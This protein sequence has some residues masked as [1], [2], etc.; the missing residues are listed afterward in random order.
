VTERLATWTRKEGDDEGIPSF[1]PELA[2]TAEFNETCPAYKERYGKRFEEVLHQ[3][4]SDKKAFIE[5]MEDNWD[6]IYKSDCTFSPKLVTKFKIDNR[7]KNIHEELYNKKPE[8][9]SYSN[10]ECT[11]QPNKKK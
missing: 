8:P 10:P 7:P 11:F 2:G 6:K 1:K 3:S 4:A 5:K 9:K